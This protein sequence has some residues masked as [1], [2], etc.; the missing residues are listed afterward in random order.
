MLDSAAL[1]ALEQADGPLFYCQPA[2]VP[3]EDRAKWPEAYR[4]AAFVAWIRKN[5]PDMV[6]FSIA[7]E[8]KRSTFAGQRMKRTGLTP[9]MADIAC[10][11]DGGMA[12]IEFKGFDKT[13]RPGKLSAQQ[14]ET[15]NR[16]HRNGHPVAM[17]YT[18][19]AARGWLR[20]LGAPIRGTI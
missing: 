2:P 13:G 8:A 10:L 19:E 5:N 6:V 4:Q 16:I 15:L 1:D 11:W 17:F 3:P 9:G 12:F 18:A 14:V 20:D 7:N